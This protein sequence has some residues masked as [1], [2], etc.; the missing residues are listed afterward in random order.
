MFTWLLFSS[1]LPSKH[2]V[3][4]NLMR[5]CSV[6]VMSDSLL[7]GFPV[8]TISRNLLKLKSVELVMPSNHLILFSPFSSCPQSFCV[9]VFPVSRLFESGGQ[10]IGASASASVLPVNFQ[11]WFPLK[12][13]LSC[14][15]Y[16]PRRYQHLDNW[17]PKTSPSC[18]ETWSFG[19]EGPGGRLE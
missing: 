17:C 16:S 1:K 5:C 9:R 4:I 2:F 10:S 14:S 12:D 15:P 3:N 11:G 18:P 19:A 7:P 8:L 13:W 6:A